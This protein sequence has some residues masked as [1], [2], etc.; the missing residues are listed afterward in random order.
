MIKR[1]VF[2]KERTES[3]LHWSCEIDDRRLHQYTGRRLRE[4]ESRCLRENQGYQPW[5][6][7]GRRQRELAVP[8]SY[9]GSARLATSFAVDLVRRG[10]RRSM[11]QN[12]GRRLRRDVGRVHAV[13][14]RSHE[15]SSCLASGFA[16]DLV[17]L[18][19]RR[20]TRS[21]RKTQNATLGPTDI[22]TRFGPQCANRS[23]KTASSRICIII[24][25]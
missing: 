15:G 4:D 21:A 18:G 2:K 19:C 9:E 6:G 20:S 7:E 11:H 16:V 24:A 5:E 22:P 13:V 17:R 12:A 23:R 3:C 1:R 25:S 14:P 8:L 10:C